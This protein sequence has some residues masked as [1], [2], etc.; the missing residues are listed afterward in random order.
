[1]YVFLRINRTSEKPTPRDLKLNLVFS[2]TD[3]TNAGKEK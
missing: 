2:G 3:Q 1:M